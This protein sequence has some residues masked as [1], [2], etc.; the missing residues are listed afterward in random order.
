MGMKMKRPNIPGARYDY[1]G[2]LYRWSRLHEKI[3]RLPPTRTAQASN[4]EL[5]NPRL[6]EHKNLAEIIDRIFVDYGVTICPDM[7]ST[8]MQMRWDD[9]HGTHNLVTINKRSV[10]A[11]FKIINEFATLNMRNAFVIKHRLRVFNGNTHDEDEKSSDV[12]S[13][14]KEF[15][16]N[17]TGMPVDSFKILGIGTVDF[18]DTYKPKHMISNG[19]SAFIPT[20]YDIFGKSYPNLSKYWLRS[21]Y[22]GFPMYYGMSSQE[23]KKITE[24]LIHT[25][26]KVFHNVVTRKPISPNE[27][28][29]D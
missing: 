5:N 16:S 8:V 26:P 18:S 7:E 17:I 2:E 20:G 22:I 3:Q 29:D 11:C 27:E 24:R 12:D 19:S 13:S 10:E 28:E 9:D 1:S 21:P 25:L 6:E 4:S 14:L 23:L 15:I